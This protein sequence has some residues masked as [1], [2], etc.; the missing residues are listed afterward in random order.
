MMIFPSKVMTTKGSFEDRWLTVLRWQ[1]WLG[2]HGN[3]PWLRSV[4]PFKAGAA[5]ADE[6]ME[7][8]HPQQLADALAALRL[9]TPRDGRAIPLSEG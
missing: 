2:T 8:P 6:F 5:M 7:E 3:P 1:R 4:F 9:A